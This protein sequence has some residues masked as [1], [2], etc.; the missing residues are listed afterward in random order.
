MDE[1]GPSVRGADQMTGERRCPSCGG[2][3]ALDAEWCGQCFAPLRREP[4]PPEPARPAEPAGPEPGA[5]PRPEPSGDPPDSAPKEPVA[6]A[7]PG[8]GALEVSGGA[9]SWDCPICGERNPLEAALCSV[10]GTPFGRLFE[11]PSAGPRVEPGTATVWSLG[12][13]GLGHWKAGLRADGVARMVLFAW[14]F[15]TVLLILI[16]RSGRG[17]GSFLPLFLLY[18]AS[19]T[20]V[21]VVSA[22]DAGRVASAR[23]P[24]VSSRVL[25]WMSAALV[26]VSI[27]MA[28]FVALPA[29]RG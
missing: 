1:S 13:P 7:T 10:C 22:M 23:A 19:A 8:G 11:E 6:V 20:A 27:V 17:L 5:A 16:S 15:G 9:A 28:T 14:T 29:T 4:E 24:V 26:L 2:L 12:F 3:A 18:L 21:Y 25:S